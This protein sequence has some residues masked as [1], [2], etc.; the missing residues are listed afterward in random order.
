MAPYWTSSCGFCPRHPGPIVLILILAIKTAQK[1][2]KSIGINVGRC[3]RFT[4]LNRILGL[5]M[6]ILH[7]KH[8]TPTCTSV[9]CKI[10][11][12][13]LHGGWQVAMYRR[14]IGCVGTGGSRW[15]EISSENSLILHLLFL[16]NHLSNF[17]TLTSGVGSCLMSSS[18]QL[19]LT[20][21]CFF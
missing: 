3:A 6:L 2:T 7:I 12:R 16:L 5:T 8:F 4:V 14:W 15:I 13:W 10:C 1:Q 11:H 19:F 21:L 17:D 18:H 20:T 9:V